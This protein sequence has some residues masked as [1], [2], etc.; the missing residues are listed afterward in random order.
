[1]EPTV[2]G[3]PNSHMMDAILASKQFDPKKT[4]MVGDNLETDILFGKNSGIETLLV[5]TGKLLSISISGRARTR[6]K[7][8]ANAGVTNKSHLE[9]EK[10]SDVDPDYIMNSLGDLAELI[11]K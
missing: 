9:G 6:L 2:I 5:M 10:K 4:L 7:I 3:K 1:M 11:E 8:I